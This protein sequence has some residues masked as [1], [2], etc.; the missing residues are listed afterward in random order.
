MS[1][2]YY[3]NVFDEQVA[4]GQ[5]AEHKPVCAQVAKRADSIP[6]YIRTSVSSRRRAEVMPLSSAPLRPQLEYCVQLWV[7]QDRKGLEMLACVQ[8]RAVRPWAVRG[9]WCM[10]SASGS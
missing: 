9:A 5:L 4:E 10:R 8:R 6:V 2:S 1:V 7:P 3:G